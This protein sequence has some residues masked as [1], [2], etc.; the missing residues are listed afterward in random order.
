ML[1][2]LGFASRESAARS[3]LESKREQK[4][5]VLIFDMWRLLRGDEKH[6]VTP[7]NLKLFLTAVLGLSFPWMYKYEEKKSLNPL[8]ERDIL[9]RFDDAARRSSA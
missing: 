6:E 5:R 8:D 4:E 2:R 3:G 9:A 1:A 7:R